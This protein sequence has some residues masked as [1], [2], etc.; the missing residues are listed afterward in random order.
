MTIEIIHQIE[1]S[2]THQNISHTS[3]QP[4]QHISTQL[5]NDT[6]HRVTVT[7]YTQIYLDSH[8]NQISA[9]AAVHIYSP[10]LPQK[11]NNMH[12]AV[13]NIATTKKPTPFANFHEP[14]KKPSHKNT[15][16]NRFGLLYKPNV[17]CGWFVRAMAPAAMSEKA[18]CFLW[19]KW[20]D[21]AELLFQGEGNRINNLV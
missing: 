2:K 1:Y 18:H 5:S 8:A 6:P 20:C 13:S 9:G 12:S 19:P 14:K 21:D 17:R 15:H 7:S 10:L 11:A 3:N 16:L 4:T